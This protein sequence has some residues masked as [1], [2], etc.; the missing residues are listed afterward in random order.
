M[1]DW[2]ALANSSQGQNRYCI[3]ELTPYALENFTTDLFTCFN[4]QKEA[5]AY[6]DANKAQRDAIKAEWKLK[7]QQKGAYDGQSSALQS[8][9]WAYYAN[10]FL[11]TWLFD[12]SNGQSRSS[13]TG[14][15]SIYEASPV[16]D[17]WLYC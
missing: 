11:N 15:W 7:H 6:S 5:D 17:T 8:G 14:V 1:S 2:L 4:T 12:L 9:H 10:S 16:N 13:H 3:Q